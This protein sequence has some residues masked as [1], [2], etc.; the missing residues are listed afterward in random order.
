[1]SR[2]LCPGCGTK[3]SDKATNCPHCGF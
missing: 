2:I 1:M 3:I